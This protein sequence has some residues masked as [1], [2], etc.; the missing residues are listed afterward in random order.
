[1]HVWDSR[2]TC[3]WLSEHV[4]S[5]CMWRLILRIILHWSYNLFIE[6]GSLNQTQ[7]WPIWLILLDSFFREIPSPTF[8]AKIK[9]GLLCL[10]D[11]LH[12]CLEIP[13]LVLLLVR[14]ALWLLSDHHDPSYIFIYKGISR[15]RDNKS[16]I[17]KYFHST[18]SI[19]HSARWG[20]IKQNLENL[21]PEMRRCPKV[22][23]S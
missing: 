9:S 4:G 5:M 17:T 2:C 11:I 14:Q 18:F 21:P 3:M 12:G 19:G 22:M 6:A 8:K 16:L 13:I 15:N 10:C 1:M 23:V 20:Y 7:S